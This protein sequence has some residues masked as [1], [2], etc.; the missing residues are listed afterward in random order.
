MVAVAAVWRCGGVAGRELIPTDTNGY[1]R[2]V[3]RHLVEGQ[4]G[5]CVVPTLVRG[6]GV[7]V[8]P[9]VRSERDI[10]ARVPV[11]RGPWGLELWGLW[12]R[13]SRERRCT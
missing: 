1:Q 12:I 6:H 10:E 8:K 3:R 11:A 4:G 5:S 2:I 13:G 9:E 7:L